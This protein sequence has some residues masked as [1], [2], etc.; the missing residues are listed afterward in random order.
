MVTDRTVVT[1]DQE[2]RGK[3]IIAPTQQRVTKEAGHFDRISP[4]FILFLF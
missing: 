2:A 1:W 4:L 3:A